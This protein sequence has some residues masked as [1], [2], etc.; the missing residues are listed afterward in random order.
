MNASRSNALLLAFSLILTGLPATPALAQAEVSIGGVKMEEEAGVPGVMGEVDDTLEISDEEEAPGDSAEKARGW[1]P[2]V[3][4]L[5]SRNS[6]F[7]K[8]ATDDCI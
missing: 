4:P 3:A 7:G 6:T 2:V 1:E 5:P 8:G